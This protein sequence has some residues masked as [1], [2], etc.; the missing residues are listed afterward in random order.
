MTKQYRISYLLPR[1]LIVLHDFIMTALLWTGLRW[2]YVRG[3]GSAFNAGFYCELMVIVF[4][5]AIMLWWSG[6][7]RGVWRFA[8]LPDLI[9]IV[10]AA[11]FG[12]CTIFLVFF[13][14]GFFS[15]LSLQTS[16]LYVPGLA[17][18]LGAPRLIYR[19][20]KDQRLASKHTDAMRVIVAGAG[21]SAEIFLRDIRSDGR[22]ETVGLLDDDPELKGRKIQGVK[23]LGRIDQLA[24]IA[25]ATAADLCVIALPTAQTRAL[26]RVVSLCD[27][28]GMPFRKL[29]RYT[30][31]LAAHDPIQLNE[32]AID[33]LLGREPIHFDWQS[34]GR[35]LG[36]KC[37][38]I[39]GAGGSI[40][41]ELARQCAQ[42]RVRKLILLE[43]AELPLLEICEELATLDPA[44]EVV[45][46]LGDCSDRVTCLRAMMHGIPDY[47]Y[48]AAA[49]KHVPLLEAQLREGL[50]NNVHATVTLAEV[51][52]DQG[53]LHFVLISTDKAIQPINILGATKLMAERFCQAIFADSATQLSIVRFGNVLDS[54]GS[55]VP[56]FRKQIAAGGPVTVTHQEVTRYFMTIPEAC[57]LILQAL[58]MPEPNAVIYTLDM[59]KPIAI[60]ELAE[61]MIRLAGKRPGVDIQIQYTGLRAGEKLHE[62]LFHPN[63]TYTHTNNPR[64]LEAEP[65]QI[66]VP[67]VLAQ[68]ELLTQALRHGDNDNQLFALLR[69]A[70]PEYTVQQTSEL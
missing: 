10:R 70:V 54:S 25:H 29:G 31:W 9:N 59:G 37:V 27:D 1:A 67:H 5:Q 17:I 12:L 48:H 55:V 19:V 45:P 47:V 8:S 14:A 39:T 57:Q 65:R 69:E 23:V 68:A 56:K 52:R 40:G 42:A 2:L 41:A 7:Y 51:C 38:L 26:Q 66:D 63:E 16:V 34:I 53:A 21:S 13:L 44:L 15:R 6:L 58:S 43:R 35:E 61:Q 36:G 4:L 50:R 64:V 30:D 60:R 62:S 20:W 11:A 24:E 49:N 22:Y 46:Q 3:D 32:V 28:V 33:D 18:F